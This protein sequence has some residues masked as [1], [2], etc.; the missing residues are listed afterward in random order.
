MSLTDQRKL[1]GGVCTP[2]AKRKKGKKDSYPFQTGG[3]GLN[4]Q[5]QPRMAKSPLK[6]LK[7]HLHVQI[8]TD[9]CLL[10]ILSAPLEIYA[11]SYDP[12]KS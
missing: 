9:S 7:V 1:D 3:S 10:E 8:T 5:I 2:N 4:R 6:N 11:L 12:S